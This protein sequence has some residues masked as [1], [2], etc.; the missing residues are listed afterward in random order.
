MEPRA[1]L[2][3]HLICYFDTMLDPEPAQAYSH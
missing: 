3:E 1:Y 2:T